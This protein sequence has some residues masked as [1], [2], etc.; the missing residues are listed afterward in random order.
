MRTGRLLTNYC[1]RQN[2]LGLEKINLTYCPLIR[3]QNNENWKLKTPSLHSQ[4]FFQAHLQSWFFFHLTPLGG[5]GQ[6]GSVMLSLSHSFLTL[7]LCSSLYSGVPPT[8]Y[9]PSWTDP[10]Q[11]AVQEA[12]QH[13]STPQSA[14]LQERAAPAWVPRSSPSRQPAASLAPLQLPPSQ[15]HLLQCGGAPE[16]PMGSLRVYLE[17]LLRC[18]EGF[19]PIS[20]S[21]LG[22][23]RAVSFTF[24]S[25]FCLS[26][27]A[28]HFLSFLK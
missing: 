2:R 10:T 24:F 23:C 19:L 9:H 26:C 12:L 16:A 17:P 27:V 22:V 6:Q 8:G 5:A 15:T 20:S 4:F 28:E 18:L 7:F 21:N 13:R 1:H 3:E 25:L 14:V 11:A